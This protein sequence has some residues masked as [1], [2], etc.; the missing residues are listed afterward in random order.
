MPETSH[1][2]VLSMG[3]KREKPPAHGSTQTIIGQ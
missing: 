2:A 3:I 1:G